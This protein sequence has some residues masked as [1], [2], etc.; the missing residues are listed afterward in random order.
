MGT[1]IEDVARAAGVSTATV[2]R[3]LRGLPTVREET[4]ARVLRA[5]AALNYVPSPSAVSLASGRT[6]TVGLLTPS[7]ARWFHAHVIEGAERTLRAAGFDVLLYALEADASMTRAA[8]DPGVLRRRVDAL[9]VVGMPVTDA[10]LESLSE[11]CVPMVFIGAGPPGRARVHMDDA[12]GSAAV[13]GELVALGHRHIGQVQGA[14]ARNVTWS[15]AVERARGAAER[16][17]A[18]GLPDDPAL[19]EAADFTTAGGRAAAAR[20]LDRAPQ[21]TAVYAHSDEMAFGVLEE[22]GARGLRVPEDVS[23][24]GIDGHDLGG[25]LGLATMAQDATG[26]GAVGATLILS[27]LA[28]EPAGPGVVFPATWTPRRSIAAPRA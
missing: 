26:Q 8:I 16:L 20:L 12:V 10:E 22:L 27:A 4:R 17:G 15:P 2:S 6:R 5:A 28:G 21:V 14:P 25:L 7:I 13:V 1:G 11:L 19:V 24:V 18:A 3:A 23:V 9:L